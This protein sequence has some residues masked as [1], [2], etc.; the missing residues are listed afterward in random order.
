MLIINGTQQ[1]MSNRGLWVAWLLLMN[2]YCTLCKGGRTS[3]WIDSWLHFNTSYSIFIVGGGLC[4]MT[5]HLHT[6]NL[7]GAIN[8]LPG[9]TWCGPKQDGLWGACSV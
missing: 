8:I 4:L 1:I 5:T 3:K 9:V 7:P 2:T 6:T